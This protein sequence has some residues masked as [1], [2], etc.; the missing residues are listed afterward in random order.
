MCEELH[1]NYQDVLTENYHLFSRYLYAKDFI[2]ELIGK[3]VL[4]PNDK[5]LITNPFINQT[6][7]QQASK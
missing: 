1:P 4:S 2:D 7:R 5:D 6:R 3:S